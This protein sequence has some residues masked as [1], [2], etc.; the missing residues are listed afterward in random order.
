[1]SV[2]KLVHFNAT[3][4]IQDIGQANYIGSVSYKHAL[5]GCVL[6][7]GRLPEVHLPNN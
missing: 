3:D 2:Y 1:M 7:A 4:L 5:Q 6:E